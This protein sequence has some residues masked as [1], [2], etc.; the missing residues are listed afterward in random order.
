M[1]M[2]GIRAIPARTY[3]QELEMSIIQP[4][5]RGL[6]T[7]LASLIAAPALVKAAN[8]M[9]VKALVEPLPVYSYDDLHPFAKYPPIRFGDR[10][11][12]AIEMCDFGPRTEEER[13]AD[14]GRFMTAK[15]RNG[16]TFQVRQIG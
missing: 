1:I 10:I 6:L 3:Q 8:I 16:G 13:L 5:R 9:P 15:F 14:F 12:Q 4:T 2:V 7:G 11:Y